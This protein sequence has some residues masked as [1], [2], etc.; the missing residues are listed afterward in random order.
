MPPYISAYLYEIAV[1]TFRAF[2]NE[3]QSFFLSLGWTN[4]QS[5]G[6]PKKNLRI[7]EFPFTIQNFS[8]RGGCLQM[9][10]RDS[11]GVKG[12]TC[13]VCPNFQPTRRSEVSRSTCKLPI[14]RGSKTNFGSVFSFR[15]TIN[16]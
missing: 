10:D 8:V 4:G 13:S 15:K 2:P 14:T 16:R 7:S 5:D 9:V 12:S 11:A 3:R 1:S 6:R